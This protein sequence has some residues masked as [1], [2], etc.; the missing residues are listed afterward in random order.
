M[1]LEINLKDG[2]A[3]DEE[4]KSFGIGR[5]T[6]PAINIIVQNE[7]R[8]QQFIPKNLKRFTYHICMRDYKFSVSNGMKFY[9]EHYEELGIPTYNTNK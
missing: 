7:R 6:A 1:Q 4:L 9:E 2:L 3:T 5:V 8:I